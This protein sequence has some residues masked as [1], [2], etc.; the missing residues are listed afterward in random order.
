M[1]GEALSRVR[2][3]LHAPTLAAA[4]GC[5]LHLPHSPLHTT[6]RHPRTMLLP[7]PRPLSHVHIVFP[8]TGGPFTAARYILWEAEDKGLELPYACR[9]GCCTACA[10]R[11]KEGSVYQPEALGISQELRDEGY[12][13]MCVGFPTSDAVLE[14]VS[15]G[16]CVRSGSVR[17]WRG[18]G[19]GR[20][21]AE[22]ALCGTGKGLWAGA[23]VAVCTTAGCA[24][25]RIHG[26]VAERKGMF[27]VVNL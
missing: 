12:A 27:C 9:M 2:R 6:T 22:G 25:A 16:G 4:P 20:T 3:R 19:E 11:V 7:S 14:T 8:G 13:L 21:T 10:V 26:V 1:R 17:F 24:C 23:A 15:G 18:R 5:A